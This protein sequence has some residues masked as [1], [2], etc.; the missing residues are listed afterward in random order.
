MTTMQQHP[1]IKKIVFVLFFTF[2][3]FVFS[4]NSPSHPWNSSNTCVDSTVFQ[5]IAMLIKKGYFPYKDTFDHKGPLLYI[6][7][8]IA[9]SVNAIWGIWLIEC[10]FLTA[11]LLFMFKISKLVCNN[12]LALIST[13]FA[14]MLLFKYYDFGNLTEEYAMIFISISL[15]IFLDYFLNNYLTNFRLIICGSCFAF[16][17][18]LRVNMVALWFIFCL[19]IFVI[20]IYQKKYT[21]LLKYISLFILGATIVTIPVLM[22]LSFNNSLLEFFNCYFLFNLTYSTSSKIGILV[23][24]MYAVFSFT[25]QMIIS[26]STCIYQYT[27]VKSNIYIIFALYLLF[28]LLTISL[29]GRNYMHYGM[30]NIPATIFPISIFIN[31]IF[32]EFKILNNLLHII[33]TIFII[34]F[35]FSPLKQ[36][37]SAYLTR[38]ENKYPQGVTSTCNVIESNSN[39]N[40]KISVYGNW[41]MIYLLTNRL[42]AS[43][44]SYQFPIGT[45]SPKIFDEY[46]NDLEKTQPV[47]IIIEPERFDKNIENFLQKNNYNCIADIPYEN[48]NDNILIYKK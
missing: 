13:F 8:Y 6:I 22:W 28:S 1:Y 10:F 47:L 41:D 15:Y 27:K 31:L 37:S 9:Y 3:S 39:E 43:K 45:V 20:C 38:H 34:V 11:T 19:S 17:F 25:P 2:C 48:S 35:L 32:N 26:V 46:F 33:L 29:P 18:L 7:N 4:I 12:L 30:I 42:P 40:D 14:S 23:I 16:V 5:T 44:Y 24:F 36:T 21:E